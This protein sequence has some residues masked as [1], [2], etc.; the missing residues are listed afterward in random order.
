[1]TQ[2]RLDWMELGKM[3]SSS[4]EN[5][6]LALSV[7]PTLTPE[8][9]K[10]LQE[11]NDT[12]NPHEPMSPEQAEETYAKHKIERD[13]L[14]YLVNPKKSEG[15]QYWGE[16]ELAKRWGPIEDATEYPWST[17]SLAQI[18]EGCKWVP[19]DQV[20]KTAESNIAKTSGL[21][22]RQQDRVD[23]LK[24]YMQKTRSGTEDKALKDVCT[25]VLAWMILIESDQ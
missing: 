1:M 25:N 10:R 19:C 24:S 9:K 6:R 2:G 11:I 20:T 12:L 22:A 23:S 7:K 14:H 13:R 8:D 16:K 3:A 21:S 4:L 17:A 18:P 5:E 15:M